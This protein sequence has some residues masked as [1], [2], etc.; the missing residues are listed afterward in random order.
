MTNIKRCRHISIRS[1]HFSRHTVS[2]MRLQRFLVYSDGRPTADLFRSVISVFANTGPRMIEIRDLR[3]CDVDV[4]GMVIRLLYPKSPPFTVI[5]LNHKAVEALECLRRLNPDSEFVLGPSHQTILWQVTFMIRSTATAISSRPFS[6]RALRK[7]YLWRLHRRS[8][9][10]R[11][12]TT[13][14]SDAE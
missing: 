9:K 14:P 2:A 3:R 7:H 10:L 12:N 13:K 4:E 11:S 5:S 1:R 8:A 6:F